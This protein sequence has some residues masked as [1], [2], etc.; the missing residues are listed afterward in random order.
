[1]VEL[2]TTSEAAEIVGVA[3]HTF[4]WQV[5]E[6]WYR[7]TEVGGRG[8]RERWRWSFID[9][10]CVRL[11]LELRRAGVR[12]GVIERAAR[13]VKKVGP[14]GIQERPVLVID[15]RRVWAC[16]PGATLTVPPGVELRALDLRPGLAR[17]CQTADRISARRQVKEKEEV[18]A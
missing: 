7:P 2:Y 4:D 12:R 9:L 17:M 11:A 6:G 3:F 14:D 10:F 13:Y 8:A 18:G 16:R 5:R 15:G 1:M